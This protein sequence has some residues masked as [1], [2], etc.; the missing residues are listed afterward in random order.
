MND[1]YIKKD[2]LNRWT[3][4]YF[5]KDLISINDL[6]D[7]IEELDDKISNLENEI[8]E[9]KTEHDNIDELVDEQI[10]MNKGV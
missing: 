9:M 3:A 1:I 5:F 2:I 7:V 8:D 4:K 6:I 10:L